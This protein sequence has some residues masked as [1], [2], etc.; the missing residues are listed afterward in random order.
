MVIQ[1]VPLQHME[2]HIGEDIHPEA[3][4][5]PDTAVG[6]YALKTGVTYREPMQK[7]VFWQ[8][9]WPTGDP[10][11]SSLFPKSCTPW[12]ETMPEQFLKNCSLWDRQSLEQFMKDC[13]PW[14]GQGKC[15]CRKDWQRQRL[16][17]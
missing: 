10:H 15:M 2:D 11:R 14:V 17:N 8:D 9:L 3:H 13:L 1:V 7:K 6:G 16:M 12:K 4:G 5:G